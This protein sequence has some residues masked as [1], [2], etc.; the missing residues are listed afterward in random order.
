MSFISWF[1]VVHVVNPDP[2]IFL[3]IAAFVADAATGNPNGIKM[4]LANGLR[5]FL[6]NGNP[7]FINDSGGLPK[8]PSNSFVLCNWVVDNFI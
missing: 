7:I 6:V 5:A 2:K 4:I 8:N 1:E 3:W